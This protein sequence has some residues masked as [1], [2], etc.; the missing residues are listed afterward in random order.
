MKAILCHKYGSPADLVIGDIPKPTPKPNEI[1]VQ[2]YATTVN[3]YDWSIVRGKPYLYRLLFG[4]SKP[5]NPVL[6]MEFSGV[7]EGVGAEVQ[8]FAVGDAIYGDSSDLH[9]GTMAEYICLET[10]GLRKKP[11]AMSHIEAA[12]LPHA[13]G[14]AIQGL[15]KA[16]LKPN[17]KILINGAGGGVGTMALQF[18]KDLNCEVT[19]VDTGEKLQW[20][21]EI[22][23]DRVIDYKTC[24]FTKEG[25][26]YD[27]ILDAKTSFFPLA[28]LRVL[29]PGAAYVTVGGELLRLIT[30]ALFGG[31][32]GKFHGKGL[33]VL[34][35]K[36]NQGLDKMERLFAAGKLKTFVDGPY[37][38]EEAPKTIQRFGDG[39]HRGKI[40]IEVRGVTPSL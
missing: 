26:Q 16:G 6:G 19:G 18:A 30:I 1:L 39:L 9:L 2:I 15:E 13:A 25:I 21:K 3:D 12:S 23:F 22:G 35:L 10:K 17:Q 4:L 36:T 14:L 29:K 24:N 32:M 28:Y 11:E 8:D 5:R 27:L 40:V 7:V 33:K 31:L 20:M 34:A 38:L 37:P